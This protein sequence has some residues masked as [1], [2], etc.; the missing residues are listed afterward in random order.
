[1]SERFIRH[2]LRED[3]L[4]FMQ[5]CTV[6]HTSAGHVGELTPFLRIHVVSQVDPG[7]FIGFRVD[8]HIQDLIGEATSDHM[9]TTLHWQ[10]LDRLT[11]LVWVPVESRCRYHSTSQTTWFSIQHGGHDD[12]MWF[13]GYVGLHQ[14]LVN[15]RVR[16]RNLL[17]GIQLL[18]HDRIMLGVKHLSGREDWDKSKWG[19]KAAMTAMHVVFVGALFALDTNLI[20]E[21]VTHPWYTALYLLLFILSL[22]QYFYTSGSPPG[23]VLEELNKNTVE[24]ADKKL[25]MDSTSSSASSKETQMTLPINLPGYGTATYGTNRG[26]WPAQ[27]TQEEE[28]ISLSIDIPGYGTTNNGTARGKGLA[29]FTQKEETLPSSSHTS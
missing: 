13:L 21:T 15:C 11:I 3:I 1:M 6:C 23:Y 25:G 16:W 12:H 19:T 28:T 7:D 22:F 24:E 10:G 27:G 2:R 5:A 8:F 17:C 4:N 9:M 29:Q 18:Q 26:K 20:R 14:S